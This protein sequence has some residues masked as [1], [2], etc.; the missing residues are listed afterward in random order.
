MKKLILTLTAAASLTMSAVSQA[1]TPDADIL[2]ESGL[3]VGHI[4]FHDPA[5]AP[6][7][8]THDQAY[9]MNY[10]S[11]MTFRAEILARLNAPALGAQ[12]EPQRDAHG[13]FIALHKE[14]RDG[15]NSLSP[16]L[17]AYLEQ[18][19]GV[20]EAEKRD[21]YQYIILDLVPNSPQGKLLIAR[22][23]ARK[24]K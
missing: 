17:R 15:W 3:T 7:Y 24:G 2:D 22:A 16:G 19:P 21:D 11:Q 1:Q 9:W 20:K 13:H 12:Q 23:R 8:Q 5:P 6:Y 4:H 10:F 18:I 14:A